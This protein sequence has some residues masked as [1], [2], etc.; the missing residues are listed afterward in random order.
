MGK[1]D[2]KVAI[3]TGGNAGV[4]K[5]IA[6]LFAS[7]GAK[8]VISARRQQVL[9]EAAKEIEA[10]G[11]TVLCVPTDISKVDDVKNLVSKTVETFGQ[12]D[13]LI[14]NA[15]ITKDGLMLRMKENDFDAVIDVNLKGTWNCMKHATKLMMKQKYGR[16]V[17]MSSVVGVMG[18]AGQVNYA[19]SKS[20][21]IGMTMS[22]AR[23]VGSRGITVNAV[24]PGFIQTAMTDV[25]SDDIKE[26]MKSQIPLGTFGSVQDI[27]NA[28]VFLASDEAKYITGQTLH[29]DGGMAM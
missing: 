3:I 13:I 16:I 27:A 21:I 4:G 8:V 6:K 18:N 24:A 23:E 20:G 29:V 1:L 11:G 10:A 12:L 19:A 25:L 7:E 5:E 26:Q 28:V 2:N 17:S 15:G 22:L 9:E 14:N